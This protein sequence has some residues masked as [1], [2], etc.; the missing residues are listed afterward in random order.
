MRFRKSVKVCPGVRLNFSKSGVSTS[1]GVRGASVT[2]GK[3]GVYANYGIPGTGI[4]N[5]E[6]ILDWNDEAAGSS[7]S[8]RGSSSSAG[9]NFAGGSGG[10]GGAAGAENPEQFQVNYLADGTFEFYQ[11]DTLVTDKSVISQIKR[12]SD[13][14]ENLAIMNAHRIEQ[15]EK[16]DKQYTGIGKQACKIFSSKEEALAALEPKFLV[17][18]KYE[19]FPSEAELRKQAESQVK[20]MKFWEKA[21]LVEEKMKELYQDALR[22]KAKFEQEEQER[23]DRLNRENRAKYEEIKDTIERISA[24]DEEA[25]DSVVSSWVKTLDFPFEFNLDYHLS[26]KKLFVDLDLP[27]I[28]DMPSKKAVKMASGIVKVK[29]KAQ[30]DIRKDYEDCVF[31]LTFF[32]AS[33]LFNIAP[34]CEEIIIS[35]YTQ[36]RDKNGRIKDIYILSVKFLRKKF[37]NL[38]YEISPK[39]NCMKFENACN[40]SSTG[41]FKEVYPYPGDI[42]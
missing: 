31:G 24:G 14:K 34:S 21:S 16:I 41:I 2:V 19:G 23:V 35:E 5:R 1:L 17:P 18:R 25:F 15:Y 37:E 28:E 12:S 11:G 39:E 27:E 4:Y 7:S 38:N 32:F 33:Y 36:R 40:Q 26:G 10:T 20:T 8:R 6:K 42:D 29:D 22:E 13:F 30:K 9:S 3:K